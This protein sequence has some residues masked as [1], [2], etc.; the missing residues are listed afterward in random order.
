MGTAL[1]NVLISS[2]NWMRRPPLLFGGVAVLAEW[3][4]RSCHN[5]AESAREVSTELQRWHVKFSA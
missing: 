3:L 5:G 1:S 4:K 2:I